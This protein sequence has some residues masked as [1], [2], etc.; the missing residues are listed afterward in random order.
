[1]SESAVATLPRARL[2]T[3]LC[4]GA[5]MSLAIGLNLL[6][7]FLI[8]LSTT[9]GG[10]SGL[11]GEQLGRLGAVVFAGLVAGIVI[12]GPLADRHGTKF[13]AQLGNAL[14]AISLIAMVNSKRWRLRE[15]NPGNFTI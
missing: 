13:F 14:T 6:P 1:M 10:T 4:Y 9:Y 2:L 7:V 3:L 8:T 11:T 12:T 15:V 5:M